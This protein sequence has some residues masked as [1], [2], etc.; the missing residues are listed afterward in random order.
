MQKRYTINVS[1]TVVAAVKARQLAELE[2]TG[3]HI[4]ADEVLRKLLKIKE[5]GK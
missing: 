3:K 1:S 4:T 5:G 2:R